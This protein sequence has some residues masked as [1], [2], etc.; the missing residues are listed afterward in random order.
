V[1]PK[2][3]KHEDNQK[4]EISSGGDVSKKMSIHELHGSKMFE[5]L[6]LELHLYKDQH[7]EMVKKI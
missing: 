2:F 7:F 6:S 3:E 1:K 4:F 5:E